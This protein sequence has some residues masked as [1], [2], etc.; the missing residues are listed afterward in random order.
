MD[1][2]IITINFNNAPGLRVTMESVIN[3][4][5]R[6]F[7]F[8]VI[9]GGS[10]DN[11][12]ELIKGFAQSIIPSLNEEGKS[13]IP[14]SWYAY[15]EGIEGGFLSEPDNGIYHAMNKGIKVAKGKY[16]QFL[17]SGDWLA[18]PNAIE[19][20]LAALPECSIFYGNML[21]L[22]PNGKVYKD[23]CEKGKISMFT[24]Y[25]GSLNHSPALIKRSLFDKYGLYDETLNI[26]SDWK[27]YLNAVGIHNEPVQYIDL[28]V[29]YF[30]MN[31]IS[32]TDQETEK[33]ERRRVLEELIPPR[34]LADYDA[35]WQKIEQ[36]I[37][38]N[39]NKI[40]KLLIGFVDR[41]LFKWEKV[42]KHIT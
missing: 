15:P 33:Q 28:D 26:V 24:F 32:N 25:R 22:L 7:E 40:T 23:T 21:K 3:Q 17:N 2:T 18:A 34:I 6:D 1:L 38:I 10:T 37:R 5:S 19:K 8:I 30:D 41:L 11:S 39:R 29:T 16:C 31:G 4:N 42:L 36:G 35:H 12:V 13:F 20:M 14:C 9:D 27:W